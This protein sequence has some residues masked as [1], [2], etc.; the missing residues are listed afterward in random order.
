MSNSS[1]TDW[2]KV[3][4]LS[5]Q[6]IDTS[7][8]PPVGNDFFAK[9]KLRMPGNPVPITL[10]VDSDVLAWFR[11]TGPGWEERVRAA[12]RIYAEAHQSS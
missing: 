5:D 4:A 2:A 11:Q 6:T 3:D 10:Q 1:R 9:A 7:Q 12:L 8:V